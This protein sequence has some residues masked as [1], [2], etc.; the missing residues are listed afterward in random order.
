MKFNFEKS[1]SRVAKYLLNFLQ[2]QLVVSL[3]SIPILVGWGLQ[4]SVMTFVGNLIFLP[5]LILFLILSSL[6]FFT[7]LCY[8]PNAFLIIMLEL[9]SCIWRAF[10][11]L[12]QRSWLFGFC[13]PSIWILL[14]I[15]AASFLI[16]Y[17]MRNRPAIFKTIVMFAIFIIV[18]AGL[19]LYPVFFK[20]NEKHSFDNGKL[21]ISIDED[22]NVKLFDNG[23][24]NRRAS[25][26]KL[27][28]YEI[29]QF[30]IK[31][32][33]KPNIQTLHIAKPGVR[34]FKAAQECCVGLNVEAVEVP[35]FETKLNKAAEREFFRLKKITAKNG[36]LFLIR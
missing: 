26:E 21:I 25:Y 13:Q 29:K 19:A 31:N 20:S 35:F 10:L 23:F 3:V 5:V 28:G 8:I 36:T 14:F 27:V 7:Q 17:L 24:F 4:T 11:S 1:K 30:L 15:P 32:T 18:I 16:L 22:F 2:A 6:V 34:S 33:G 9:V 12:G